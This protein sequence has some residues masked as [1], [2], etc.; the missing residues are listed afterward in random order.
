MTSL[1]NHNI[2]K[3]HVQKNRGV[4]CLRSPKRRRQLGH[5]RT[6]LGDH[7]TDK[8]GWIP[9]DMFDMFQTYWLFQHVNIEILTCSWKHVPH[10]Q[11]CRYGKRRKST[12]NQVYMVGIARSPVIHGIHNTSPTC[13]Q[14]VW[15]NCDKWS[16]CHPNQQ[17]NVIKDILRHLRPS[18]KTLWHAEAHL[19]GS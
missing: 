3:R 15:H 10:A 1:K 14:R 18:R 17:M 7:E 12:T 13:L 19:E 16:Q 6:G 5:R 11:K 9:A 2:Y 8:K 4:F